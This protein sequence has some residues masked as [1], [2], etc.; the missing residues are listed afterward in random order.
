MKNRL[1]LLLL[2]RSGTKDLEVNVK[3]QITATSERAHD[4]YDFQ[5]EIHYMVHNNPDLILH[6]TTTDL[7]DSGLGLYVFEP[8][9][10]GQSITVKSDTGDLNRSA[11]VRW[12]QELR[13]NVYRVGLLFL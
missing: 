6:G 8:L 7:S 11:V 5:R 3:K 2:L 12:C 9:C 1:A 13:D 4:R 10:E